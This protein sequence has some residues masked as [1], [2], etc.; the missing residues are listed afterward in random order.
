M[1]TIN[2]F[3]KSIGL[4]LRKLRKIDRALSGKFL[5]LLESA[6]PVADTIRNYYRK[7]RTLTVAQMVTLIADP[8][9]IDRL[10]PYGDA[11]RAILAE[12]GD[13]V[14]APFDAAAYIDAASRGD[15]DAILR[16]VKWIKTTLPDYPVPHAYLATRLLLGVPPEMREYEAPRMSRVMLNCRKHHEL[17]GW[18][19]V[20]E[21][22]GRQMTLYA[23]PGEYDL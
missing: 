17:S 23:R 5:P 21:R 4:S 6:D 1:P 20:A 18:W 11:M 3:A 8:A 9:I 10:K 13:V 19:H 7:T 22:N 15:E 16:I 2:E 12:L 14:P